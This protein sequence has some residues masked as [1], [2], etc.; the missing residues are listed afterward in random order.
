MRSSARTQFRSLQP[1]LDRGEDV[2][3]AMYAYKQQV[4]ATL[5]SS[6]D[7][8][9]I[10]WTQDKWNKALNFRDPKTN[11]YRQMDLWE[12]NTYLRSLPEWQ[13]TDEANIAYGNLAQS[14]ARGFG[15]TA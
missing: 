6:I 4:G 5:G 1:A 3:T 14:L 8:S 10:D 12:W 11:E 15:K 2:D 9:Q 13:N 7:V